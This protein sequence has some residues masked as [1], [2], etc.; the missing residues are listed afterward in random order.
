MRW[1]QMFDEGSADQRDLLG[2][3]GANLAEMTR[4]G[5]PVPPGFTV[6]TDA[7]R[8]WL[9]TGT[10]PDDLMGEV[11]EAVARVEAA[12]GKSLGDPADPLLLSVRSGS[13]FSMPG[14]M[15]TVLDLGLNPVTLEGLAT[16]SGDPRFAHDAHRR[17]VDLFG[18]VV[19]GVPEEA[20]EEVVTAHVEAAGVRDASD[21]DADGARQLADEIQQ[22]VERH[23][24]AVFP[25]DPWVQLEQAI[26]AVFA[27]WNGRRAKTYRQ[28]EGIPDDL[29][30]A[31][32]V[33]A[34]VFGN[35]GETSATGVGF[36]R[37]P[38]TGEN[39]FYSTLR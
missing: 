12:T 10:L 4:M 18:R 36:T 29:G 7:C 21:L 6:T 3:K 16:H 8:E 27:S 13:K 9:A 28:L 5:L 24:G 1:V 34:M 38:A 19:L 23:H 15:D 25:D 35:L 33:Q 30:T 39:V 37:N 17:F 2:G 14:M 26:A 32:N 11:R 22:V 20:I 31:V